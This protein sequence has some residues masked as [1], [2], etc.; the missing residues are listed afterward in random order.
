MSE[1]FLDRLLVIVSNLHYEQKSFIRLGP[2]NKIEL[3]SNSSV[4]VYDWEKVT[5][6]G[7][8]IADFSVFAGDIDEIIQSI[9]NQASPAGKEHNFKL[10]EPAHTMNLICDLCDLFGALSEKDIG[11]FLAKI[12]ISIPPIQVAQYIFLLTKCEMLFSRRKG[13]G[14]YYFVRDWQSRISFGLADNYKFYKERIQVDTLAFY[15][16]ELSSRSDVIKAIRKSK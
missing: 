2:L 11:D 7:R 15:E 16:K 6:D 13:H 4:L 9:R 12:G 5:H 14:T 10:S 1:P 8:P 3:K